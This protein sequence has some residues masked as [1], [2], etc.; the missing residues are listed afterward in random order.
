MFY[1]CSDF[2]RAYLMDPKFGGPHT[3]EKLAKLEEYLKAFTTALKRQNFDL[4]YFDA[5]A[6]AGAIQVADDPGTLLDG[7][8]DFSPFVEGSALRALKLGQAFGRYVFVDAKKKNVRRLSQLIGSNPEIADRVQ[9]RHGDANEELARFCADVDWR[10]T[11]AVV[12]LDPYGNQVEWQTV[13]VIA[14][15]KGIDLWYLFPAGLGVHR[16]ISKRAEVHRSHE[17]SLDR[18]LGTHEW[19]QAFIDAQRSADLFGE[20]VATEKRATPD[21]ITRFMIDRMKTVFEGGVLDEWLPLGSRGIHMYSLVFAWANPS[22]KAQLA[23]KL[24]KAVLRG[25]RGRA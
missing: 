16:Q 4:I 12:F 14:R 7:V 5:F 22:E 8:D 1:V 10:K 25:R 20:R 17:A 9:V 15:T 23:G 24:A 19:R 3:Q 13:E 21:S 18:L 2:E 6:G 11:R